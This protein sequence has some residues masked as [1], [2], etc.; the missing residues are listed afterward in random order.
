LKERLIAIVGEGPAGQEDAN[1]PDWQWEGESY[2]LRSRRVEIGV[3]G[4]GDVM[5]NDGRDNV[6]E[7][8]QLKDLPEGTVAIRIY[9]ES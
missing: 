3:K 5:Y 6:G 4:E 9:A 8:I 2:E 1:G 7:V